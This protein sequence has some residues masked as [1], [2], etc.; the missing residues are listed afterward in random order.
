MPHDLPDGRPLKNLVPDVNVNHCP[1]RQR[2]LKALPLDGPD[3]AIQRT[4][5][6]LNSYEICHSSEARSARMGQLPYRRT[7]NQPRRAGEYATPR[8]TILYLP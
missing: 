5:D 8:S 7:A 2:H 1:G 4:S 3:G 6:E